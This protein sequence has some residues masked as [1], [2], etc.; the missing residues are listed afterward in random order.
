MTVAKGHVVRTEP[1]AGTKQKPGTVVNLVIS[2]GPPPVTIPSSVIG[3]PADEVEHGL[4]TLGLSVKRTQANDD[5]I[6]SGDVIRIE[7]GT[8]GT[9]AGKLTVPR[10]TTVTMVVSKGPVMVKVPRLRGMSKS[11]AEQTLRDAGLVPDPDTPLYFGN[12]VYGQSPSADSV[13][14]HGTTVRFVILP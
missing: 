9:G 5:N 13:V 2:Q 6:P 4:K 8:A 11:D 1:A 14:P 12:T 10:G 3:K 7:T